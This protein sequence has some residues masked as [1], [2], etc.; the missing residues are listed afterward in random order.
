MIEIDK[1]IKCID[2]GVVF[3]FTIGEQTFYKDR[4]FTEPKRCQDCRNKKKEQNNGRNNY[5]S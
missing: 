1:E 5:T 2:C 4:Q 3:T